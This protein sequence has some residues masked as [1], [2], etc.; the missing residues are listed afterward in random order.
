MYISL[1]N[2]SFRINKE[3]LLNDISLEVKSGLCYGFV[4]RN[5]CGK[6]MLLRCIAGYIETDG[7]VKYNGRE[8]EKGE[9]LQNAG[10]IIGE[11]DFIP[12]LSGFQ[13]L[14][15]LAEINK[16]VNDEKI[17]D[18][19]E[20]VGLKQEENKKYRKYSLGMKQRLRIAQAIMDEPKLL[21]LDEPFNGLDKSG[22]DDII[23]LLKTKKESGITILLTSHNQAD[24]VQLCDVVFE[25][26]KGKIINEVKLNET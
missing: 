21:I 14:K 17:H 13:N 16:K 22:C 8:R 1:E 12:L 18:V 20:I 19:M 23:K 25:M 3:E 24:I 7:V 10:M 11:T 2:V 6:T 9:F 15:A 5:G 4:G 26:D